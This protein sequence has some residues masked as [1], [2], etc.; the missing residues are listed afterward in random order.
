MAPHRQ[1]R[2]GVLWWIATQRKGRRHHAVSL[3]IPIIPDVQR[4]LAPGGVGDTAFLV[5]EYG[6]PFTVAG[7]GNRFR[8]W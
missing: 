5:N 1:D 7:F 8:K 6:R 3:D 2:D 4:C